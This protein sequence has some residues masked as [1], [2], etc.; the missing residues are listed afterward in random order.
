[1]PVECRC[2]CRVMERLEEKLRV[3][4]RNMIIGQSMTGKVGRVQYVD[5]IA[6]VSKLESSASHLLKWTTGGGGVKCRFTA[7]K[8]SPICA[9]TA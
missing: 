2:R 6:A 3:N 4:S 5:W 9:S 1:M 8:L 7:Y